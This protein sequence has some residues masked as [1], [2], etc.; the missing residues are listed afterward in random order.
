MIKQVLFFYEKNVNIR[1][2]KMSFFYI[3]K[4]SKHLQNLQIW[5]TVK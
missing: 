1:N 4:G 2:Q 5:Y 3:I